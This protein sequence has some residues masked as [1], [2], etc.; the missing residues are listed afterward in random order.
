MGYRVGGYWAI[1]AGGTRTTAMVLDTIRYTRESVNPASA[2]PAAEETL[3]RLL[4]R[5]ASDLGGVST[6]WFA[7]ST[8]TMDTAPGAIDRLAAIARERGFRGRLVISGDVPPLL[9]APPLSGRGV[10]VVSGTGSACVAS[11]GPDAGPPV[12]IG[13]C[14]YLG[15]DEGS[16][17]ALGEAGLRAAVRG[18]DGRGRPTTLFAASGPREL[19]RRLAAGPFPKA[20]VAAL[21]PEVCVAWQAGDA[22]AGEVVRGG[23]DELVTGVRAARD[24]AG[25]TGTWRAVLNGG[26]FRGCPPYAAELSRRI[27]TE[28][29]AA[30][31]PTVIADP[32]AAI[33]AALLANQGSPPESW[34][35]IRN[36]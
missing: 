17:Y 35:H 11:A 31:P 7:S 3:V 16:A 29:G 30:E 2:G 10:V 32:V 20:A 23:L 18:A 15:S 6:G 12:V 1:D 14:E 5:I 24:A 4:S 13:G 34:A 9:L 21:A 19:A 27:V 22:V 26:V 8:I 36:L 33:Y 25:L 28:L